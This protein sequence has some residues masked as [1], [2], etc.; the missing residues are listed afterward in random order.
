MEFF[1]II[2]SLLYNVERR[3]LGLPYS[4]NR[5]GYKFDKVHPILD[6]NN[7]HDIETGLYYGEDICRITIQQSFNEKYDF[8]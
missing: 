8:E 7:N 5:V 4:N 2:T 6:F 1:N 3:L